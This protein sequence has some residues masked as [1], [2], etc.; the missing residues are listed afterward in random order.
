M[1]I[2]NVAT[3]EKETESLSKCDIVKT[4]TET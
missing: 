2:V 4:E 1:D 3:S